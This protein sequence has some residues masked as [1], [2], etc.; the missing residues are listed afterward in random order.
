MA[1]AL[2]EAVERAVG[3]RVELLTQED[4]QR[5]LDEG[6][7]ARVLI[8]PDGLSDALA[9]SEPLAVRLVSQRQADA[10]ETEALR[11]AVESA[12]Q[13]LLLEQ[14][15]AAA[16]RGLSETEGLAPAVAQVLAD[17]RTVQRALEQL[18]AAR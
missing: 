7:T 16:L 12:L 17:E 14:Q 18:A 8:L 13:E 2:L 6:Q 4:A 3:V 9:S 5:R 1:Q 10:E 11:L 15:V